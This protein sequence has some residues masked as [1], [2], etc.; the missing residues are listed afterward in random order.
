MARYKVIAANTDHFISL[1]EDYRKDMHCVT[2]PINNTLAEF[3]DENDFLI[4]LNGEKVP[5]VYLENIN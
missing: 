2:A 5:P 3:E 4:L 1:F